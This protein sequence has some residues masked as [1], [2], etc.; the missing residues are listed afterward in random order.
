MMELEVLILLCLLTAQI[1]GFVPIRN[2]ELNCQYS[3]SSS[4]SSYSSKMVAYKD[5]ICAKIFPY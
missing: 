3:Y 4:N 2:L 5:F 1:A